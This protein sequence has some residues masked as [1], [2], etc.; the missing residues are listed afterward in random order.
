MQESFCVAKSNKIT[1][2]SVAQQR[3]NSL[4]ASFATTDTQ[5]RGPADGEPADPIIVEVISNQP[6]N[7][8]LCQVVEDKLGNRGVVAVTSYTTYRISYIVYEGG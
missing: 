6:R 4:T 7:R 3:K 1:Q 8:V 5:R 2:T